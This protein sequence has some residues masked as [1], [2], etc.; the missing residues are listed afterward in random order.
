MFKCPQNK[1]AIKVQ[2]EMQF[3]DN[4]KKLRNGIWASLEVSS[5]RPDFS[6]AESICFPP[7]DR[8]RDY[9][10]CLEIPSK[11]LFRIPQWQPAIF[12]SPLPLILHLPKASLIG[13]ISRDI[14][15]PLP[16]EI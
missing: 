6:L 16:P 5:R 12:P 7:S 11:Y 15:R 3:N 2:L 13:A 4:D 10:S 8:S 14:I 1:N 9:A